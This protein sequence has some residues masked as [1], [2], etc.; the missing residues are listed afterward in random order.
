MSKTIVS[1]IR[2]HLDEV[3]AAWMLKRYLPEFKDAALEFIPTGKDGGEKAVVPGKD[4]VGVGRGRFDEHKGDESDCAASL[5]FKHLLEQKVEIDSLQLRGLAKLVEWVREGDL[6]L[7][8]R[9]PNRTF[10]VHSILAYHRALSGQGDQGVMAL[11]FTICDA[12]LASQMD[13]AQLEEDWDKRTEFVSI[14]GPAVAFISSCRDQDTFAYQHGF[15]LAVYINKERTYHNIRAFAGSRIDLTPL[16]LQLKQVEPEA[17]WYFHHSKKMLI[18]GG[19]LTAGARSSKLSL[20]WLVDA[21][22][23]NYVRQQRY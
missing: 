17:D 3:L 21:L 22:T 11:G 13:V 19:D 8:N 15:D 12:L 6:G 23:P 14:Y 20:E 2:P 16:Y 9:I 7:Q 4:Y 1:H 5:V 10:G 18:C